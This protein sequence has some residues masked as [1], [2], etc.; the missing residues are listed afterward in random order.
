MRSSNLKYKKAIRLYKKTVLRIISFILFFLI[1]GV[2]YGL[3]KQQELFTVKNVQVLGTK[4]YV[5]KNDVHTLVSTAIKSKNL[6]NLNKKQMQQD[7][8]SNFQGV[9]EVKISRALNGTVNVYVQERE[10]IA[11]VMTHRDTFG[12]D[13]DG[14]VLGILDPKTTNLPRLNYNGDVKVGLFIDKMLVPTY[15]DHIT[16]ALQNI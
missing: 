12:V 10:P 15:I 16:M 3:V 5:N 6:F 7:I 8:K 13:E 1:L 11:L 2:I 14:Y 4:S 9:K